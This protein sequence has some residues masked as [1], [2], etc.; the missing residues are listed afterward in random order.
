M[1]ECRETIDAFTDFLRTKLTDDKENTTHTRVGQPSGKYCINEGADHNKFIELYAKIC[2][3]KKPSGE[4]MFV[5]NF[6]EKQKEIGPLMTDYDFEFPK[7]QIARRYTLSDI[8]YV[9]QKINALLKEYI[10]IDDDSDIIAY[11]TEKVSPTI[12]REKP[13]GTEQDNETLPIKK[14]KDGFHICYL[15]PLT[16]VQRY[17][18]YNQLMDVIKKEDGFRKIGMKNDYESIIDISTIDRNNWMMYGSRKTLRHPYSKPYSLTHI[19]N[20]ELEE[21]DLEKFF[22]EFNYE[23]LVKFFSVRQFCK[24]E[25]YL[26]KPEKIDTEKDIEEKYCKKTKKN[27][28]SPIDR[29]NSISMPNEGH[30]YEGHNKDV[31]IARKLANVLSEK[32]ASSYDDW[33]HVGWTLHNIDSSLFEAFV[34]FSQK[35]TE[36]F[37][38]SGCEK[39]WNS[40]TRTNGYTIASLHWWA[41]M[42]S[43]T[44]YQKVIWDSIDQLYTLAKTGKPV[45]IAVIMYEL[46]KYRFKCVEISGT[47]IN[48]F[49]FKNHRWTRIPGATALRHEIT[50]TLPVKILELSQAYLVKIPQSHAEDQD[51]LRKTAMKILEL[52]SRLADTPFINNI[53]TECEHQFLDTEFVEHLDGK[54]N[55]IGFTNGVYDLETGEFRNGLPE[56]NLSLSTK[57]DWIEYD[58]NDEVFNEL[59]DYITKLMPNNDIREYLLK[60]LASYLDGRIIEQQFVFWTGKGCHSGD[61]KILMFNGDTKMAK[62]VKIGDL[63]MGDDSKPRRVGGLFTGIQEMYE[64]KLSDGSSYTVNANHRLALKSMFDGEI[65]FDETSKT[66]VVTYHIYDQYIPNKR[67]KL[68]RVSESNEELSHKMAIDYLNKKRMSSKFIQLNSIIPVKVVDYLKLDESIKMHYRNYRNPITFS[69][70]PILVD[71]YKIGMTLG[72][73]PIPSQYKFNSEQIRKHMLAGILDKFGFIDNGKINVKLENQQFMNDVVFVCRSLGYHV[74]TYEKHIELIGCFRDVPTKKFKIYNDECNIVHDLMYEFEIRNLGIGRFYGFSVDQNERYVLQN[75]VVTYNSN[76]KTMFTKLIRDAFGEYY[77]VM[78]VTVLT[79]QRGNASDATPQLANKQGKRF[80]V[81]QESEEEDKIHVGFM[82]Q[83]TG[84]D[85]ITARALFKNSCSYSP[86]FKI[87]MVC[88]NLPDIVAQDEGTWRRIVVIPFSSEFVDDKPIKPNQFTKDKT[89]EQ[90]MVKWNTAFMWL[91]LKKYYPLYRKKGLTPPEEI[92][93]RTNKFRNEN[94]CINEFMHINYDVTKKSTDKVQFTQFCSAFR[95]WYRDAYGS[96]CP[97]TKIIKSYIEKSTYFTLEDNFIK[98]LREKTLDHADENI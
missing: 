71:P 84:G 23:N 20:H 72:T 68:F 56:D 93:L 12:E 70:Q 13:K 15:I 95:S 73:T 7:E 37:D 46:Y 19:F 51:L 32:R 24:G 18:I 3:F 33:I 38:R 88:N 98:G 29:I 67:E 5:H 74:S 97:E 41:Q 52:V 69:Q 94:D 81:M 22:G 11:V 90:K 87:V 54:T 27:K 61:T 85:Q 39:V 49:E 44:E 6:S 53:I 92:K 28:T 66:Y 65:R 82:K 45:S 64:I 4:D 17:M 42:D 50:S 10:D 21:M 63:L 79:R 55:I 59:N 30:H 83:V 25:E 43:P 89:I 9:I 35:N 2:E 62:D 48:W 14:I 96:K 8:K 86:Q 57:Y 91:L 78:D 26:T 36:K 60:Q 58:E 16:R 80:I 31:L 1:G 77:D 40:E 76:G 47:H 34:S 75:F